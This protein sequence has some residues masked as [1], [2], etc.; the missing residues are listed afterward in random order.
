MIHPIE[1]NCTDIDTFICYRHDMRIV[2]AQI[3]R[4]M[5]ADKR[6]DYGKVWYS[7]SQSSGNYL[8]DID[9]LLESA[10]KVILVLGKGFLDGFVDESTGEIKDSLKDD[11]SIRITIKELQKI[12]ELRERNEIKIFAVNVDGYSFSAAEVK[13]LAKILAH[14]E[15]VQAKEE[16]IIKAWAFQNENEI[17]LDSVIDFEEVVAFWEKRLANQIKLLFLEPEEQLTFFDERNYAEMFYQLLSDKTRYPNVAYFGYAGGVFFNNLFTGSFGYEKQ[18]SSDYAHKNIRIL[19][20]NPILEAKE[21][22]EQEVTFGRRARRK[23]RDMMTLYDRA[24]KKNEGIGIEVRFY[25]H[26]P[27]I[28]GSIFCDEEWNPLAGIINFESAYGASYKEKGGS[29]FKG[30]DS[31]MIYFNGVDEDS[32]TGRK[33]PDNPTMK[34]LMTLITQFN[35]DWKRGKID[36]SEETVCSPL[37]LSLQDQYYPA[38]DQEIKKTR[39]CVRAV[40]L[41]EENEVALH[42]VHRDDKYGDSIYYEL[43]G[44]GVELGE[45]P[46]EALQREVEEEAGFEIECLA[47]L[48]DAKDTYNL[49]KRNNHHHIFLARTVTQGKK[50]FESEGDELIME[51]V[52]MPIEEAVEAMQKQHQG[53]FEGLVRQRELPFLILVQN[54]LKNGYIK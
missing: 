6:R 11:L 32:P 39:E 26:T 22:R 16:D 27:F 50:H 42:H 36:V 34:A 29:P 51:T 19:L 43:P 35:M 21:E 3:K 54:L 28:K 2:A 30:I 53:G 52:F 4:A 38:P 47:Y 23:S 20:R 17:P 24:K 33:A 44:G 31:D 14:G 41:N 13:K 1:A 40:L 12:E 25:D 45:E 9:P 7:N 37:H 8:N 18:H 49:A 46:F 10:E 15:N 48:G 5:E